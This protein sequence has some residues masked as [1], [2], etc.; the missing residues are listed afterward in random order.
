MK[1]VTS[2]GGIIVENGKAL[3][4]RLDSGLYAIPKGH[5]EPGETLE[6]TALREMAEE[7]GAKAH[8]VERLGSLVRP[9]REDD[10]V[11]VDKTI[12]VFLMRR[13]GDADGGRDES[14]EWVSFED[15]L[16]HMHFKEEANFLREH[17][18]ARYT[19]QN[20]V[21]C[22]EVG[23]RADLL[24]ESE[25]FGVVPDNHPLVEG[26]LLIIPKGH[27]SCVGAYT[28]QQRDE[29]LTVYEKAKEFVRRHYGSVAT[30][31]HGVFGQ[32]INHSH[33]HVLPAKLKLNDV[34]PEGS[35][36]CRKIKSTDILSTEFAAQGGYLYLSI[37]DKQWL[38]DTG[39]AA[40]RFFR[41]RFAR[42]LGV[43]DC[44][45]WKSAAQH[46]P[47]LLR[48]FDD[49]KQRVAKTWQQMS[50]SGM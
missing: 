10:G 19:D 15:A 23:N 50:G 41:D 14:S 6:Q 21:L 7:T 37:N 16:S 38:V 33:V 5:T 44:M 24:Y 30:F 48:Q 34:I 13:I 26:H 20:C 17:V 28:S 3:L 32:T 4:V 35:H 9:S 36:H 25:F 42:A 27:V 2:A 1:S 8:I 40:Q 12:V 47:E 45:D 31:E 11:L 18:D 43:E 39:L 49:E 29:F 46:N 22:D